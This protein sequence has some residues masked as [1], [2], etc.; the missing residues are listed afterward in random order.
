MSDG[1]GGGGAR[2]GFLTCLLPVGDGLPYEARLGVV[3]SHQL[4]LRLGDPDK[5]LF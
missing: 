5:A 1:F 3:V 4:W 2:H